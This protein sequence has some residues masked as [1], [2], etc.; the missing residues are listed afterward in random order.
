MVYIVDMNGWWCSYFLCCLFQHYWVGSNFRRIVPRQDDTERMMGPA[1]EKKGTGIEP[2]HSSRWARTASSC[3]RIMKTCRNQSQVLRV[4][5]LR[6]RL[7][8]CVCNRSVVNLLSLFMTTSN[9]KC[10]LK[11]CHCDSTHGNQSESLQT[12]PL[13]AFPSSPSS[14]SCPGTVSMETLK[15][16]VHRGASDRSG[17]CLRKAFTELS[18]SLR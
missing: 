3:G 5:S 1:P 17:V 15:Q 16:T 2:V 14:S 11:V 9:S 10:L 18:L 7:W 12:A 4:T 13:Q 8:V 6:N